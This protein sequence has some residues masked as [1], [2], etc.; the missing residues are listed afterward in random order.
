MCLYIGGRER[1][2]KTDLETESIRENIKR[3][4]SLLK[5]SVQFSAYIASI[6][7]QNI[8]SYI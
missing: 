8:H 6:K 4:G 2:R 5:R 3:K 1:S 7:I